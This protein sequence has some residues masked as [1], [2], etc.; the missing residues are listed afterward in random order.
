MKYATYFYRSPNS[1][2]RL[3]HLTSEMLPPPL[4]RT[5][6]L[7]STS[8]PQRKEYGFEI[9]KPNNV[10]DDGADEMNGGRRE[11]E[12]GEEGDDGEDREKLGHAVGDPSWYQVAVLR[13]ELARNHM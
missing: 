2:L 10:E 5:T 6:T 11:R 8:T 1:T 7:A 4:S 9:S 13:E 3:N 12:D